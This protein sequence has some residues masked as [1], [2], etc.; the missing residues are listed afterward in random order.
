MKLNVIIVLVGIV[1]STAVSNDAFAGK[2]ED[3]Y[4]QAT[5]AF[6]EK[7]LEEGSVLLHKAYAAAKKDD[8]PQKAVLG[9]NAGMLSVRLS[10]LDK[11]EATLQEV[12]QYYIADGSHAKQLNT[13]FTVLDKLYVN[14]G[15]VKKALTLIN[16]RI[17]FVASTEGLLSAQTVSL[18]SEKAQMTAA[19]GNPKKALGQLGGLIKEL[20]DNNMEGSASAGYVWL[21]RMGIQMAI[22]PYDEDKVLKYSKRG[23][24]IL[25]TAL[26]SGDPQ[27]IKLYQDRVAF[28]SGGEKWKA[29]GLRQAKIQL[30]EQMDAS[31]KK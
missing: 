30:E 26:P 19:N 25:L 17:D 1:L 10:Q 14:K 5:R 9:Y 8:H 22:R 13:I 15:D 31:K 12:L 24:K 27:L 3:L 29:K 4:T 28:F 2:V 16:E 7:N 23:E 20:A 18:R 11:A 6:A 21:R